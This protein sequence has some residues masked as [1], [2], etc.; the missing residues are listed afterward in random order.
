[1]PKAQLD[2]CRASFGGFTKLRSIILIHTEPS[3]K[4]GLHGKSRVHARRNRYQRQENPGEDK[5]IDD[6]TER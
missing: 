6:N 1:M 3:P 5:G 4:H 2:T